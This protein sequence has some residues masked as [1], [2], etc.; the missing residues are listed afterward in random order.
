MEQRLD[1]LERFE[2]LERFEW[3]DHHS[4]TPRY[5]LRRL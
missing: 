1:F 4:S 5:K 2:R 3:N